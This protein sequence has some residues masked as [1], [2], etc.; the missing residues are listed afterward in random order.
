MEPAFF[1]VVVVGSLGIWWAIYLLRHPAGRALR[2]FARANGLSLER[3]GVLSLIRHRVVVTITVEFGERA[4]ATTSVD[5]R[6]TVP[7]LVGIWGADGHDPAFDVMP[8]QAHAPWE[9]LLAME[10]RAT[11]TCDGARVGVHTG[12]VRE[13]AVFDAMIELAALLARWD[14]GLTEI[15][16]A[17]PGAAPLEEHELVPGAVLAPDDLMIGVRQGA[18]TVAQ[19]AGA[20]LPSA[21][22]SVT[23]GA[24]DVDGELPALVVA[25][26]R[27]VGTAEL[28]VVASGA[29]LTWPHVEREPARLRAGVDVLRA[30]LGAAGPYR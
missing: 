1:Y 30:V 3:P 16:H 15:M 22:A 13:A 17:L 29:R 11:A 4:P 6:V 28:L 23:D 5:A 27:D 20:A 14:D 2:R 18:E 8:G 10:P 24:V 9:A 25:R 26:L 19:V 12:E 21:T 7:G